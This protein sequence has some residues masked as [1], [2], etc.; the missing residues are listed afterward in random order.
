MRYI[1][2]SEISDRVPVI[3]TDVDFAER[4]IESILGRSFDPPYPN[5]L[6]EAVK[7][8]ALHRAC[9]R[10][11]QTEDTVWLDKAKHYRELANS[12]IAAL[13]TEL[14]KNISTQKAVRS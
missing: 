13:Q 10:L 14:A 11:A 6:K 1:T 7:L 2:L 5:I 12:T 8:V 3:E 4:Y 9:V